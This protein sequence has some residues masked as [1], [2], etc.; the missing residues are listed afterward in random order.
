[1]NKYIYSVLLLKIELEKME[2]EIWIQKIQCSNLG[3]G[4]DQNVSDIRGIPQSS[5]SN[6]DKTQEIIS[7]LLAST[8]LQ[9]DYSLKV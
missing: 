9:A 1:M 6:S 8:D 4:I 7:V 5:S 3:K 2:L